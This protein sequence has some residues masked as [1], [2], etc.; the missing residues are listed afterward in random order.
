MAASGFE[1]RLECG[2]Y[3]GSALTQGAFGGECEGAAGGYWTEAL[4]PRVQDD[5][6]AECDEGG[7]ESYEVDGAPLAVAQGVADPVVLYLEQ[8]G[9]IPLLTRAEE[10]SLAKKIEQS[11]GAYRLMLLSTDFMIDAAVDLL[12][13]VDRDELSLDR[14]MNVVQK[15]MDKKRTQRELLPKLEHQLRRLR[16]EIRGNARIALQQGQDLDEV[17]RPAWR[18][19]QA[20]RREAVR[21]IEQAEI[22]LTRVEAKWRQLER[23]GARMTTLRRTLQTGDATSLPAEEGAAL[24]KELRRCMMLTG[25]SEA[26]L[27][28]RINKVKQLGAEYYTAKRSL[29]E[30]NLRL[31]VSVAKRYRNLGLSFLDLIQD[32]NTGLLHAVDKFEYQRGFKFSTYAT[33][34]IRQA[35][36]RGLS[37]TGRTIRIPSHLVDQLSALCR[38]AG[39][40]QQETGREPALEQTA[41]R[42]GMRAEQIERL[43]KAS[44]EVLQL[45]FSCGVDQEQTIGEVL[46]DVRQE[47]PEVGVTRKDLKERMAKLLETLPQREKRVLEYRYGLYDGH[48]YT[49][50]ETGRIFKLS[51]ERIRQIELAALRKLQMPNNAGELVGF[52]D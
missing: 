5:I 9:S 45:D 31:V 21:L 32:G 20:L 36:T 7:D 23:I 14:T 41:A 51:R 34:W 15:D 48:E 22:R 52:L 46:P 1:R 25:E 13:K 35:I 19:A 28:T 10:I 44:G 50:A 40:L 24:R 17:R 4:L 27:R 3:L 11:R 16:E 38:E 33:F 43:R 39:S 49:L 29:S 30:G 8:I 47:A 26:T 42:L 12:K 18:K 2:D 37:D 6:H